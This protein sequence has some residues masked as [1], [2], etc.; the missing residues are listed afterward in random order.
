MKA[1][2]QNSATFDQS[3]SA[4][5]LREATANEAAQLIHEYTKY[6]HAPQ[7]TPACFEILDLSDQASIGTSSHT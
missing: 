7:S 6:F 3:H 2:Q 1:K 5:P 4:G